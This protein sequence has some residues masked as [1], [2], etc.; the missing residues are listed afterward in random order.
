MQADAC[1]S[2]WAA[3]SFGFAERHLPGCSARA[4]TAPSYSS[5]QEPKH[6]AEAPEFW[7]N[8]LVSTKGCWHV[9]QYRTTADLHFAPCSMET[10]QLAESFGSDCRGKLQ[11]NFGQ[12]LAP[13]F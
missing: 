1:W 13:E 6:T 8:L 4:D 5:P 10:P 9:D 12:A 7:L 2:D 11:T 3:P